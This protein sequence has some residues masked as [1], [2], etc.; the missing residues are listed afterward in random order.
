MEL[1]G[2]PLR[3]DPKTRTVINDLEATAKLRRPYRGP[4]LHPEPERV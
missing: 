1:G 4:W 3:Y 2:R